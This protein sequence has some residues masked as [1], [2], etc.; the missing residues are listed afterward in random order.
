MPHADSHTGAPSLQ[1]HQIMGTA[2]HVDHGKTA[3]IRALTGIE[4]DTH[5]EEKKRGIT[6]NLGFAFLNTGNGD[7]IGIVDVP[8]H[9]DFVNTMVAGACGMDFVCL[10]IAAD[11]G[12]MP[13]T[14]EHLNIIEALGIRHGIV[15]LTKTDIV[16]EET[17]DMAQQEI[18]E[19]LEPSALNQAPV[20]AVSSATGQGIDTLKAAIL[21]VAAAVPARR[22]GEVFRMFADRIFMVKGFGAVVTGS[23]LSGSLSRESTVLL[24]PGSGRYRV[25]RM[26]RH[27]QEVE[28][29]FTG[30]RAS[31]NLVGLEKSAFSRGMVIADRELRSTRLLDVTIGL[32]AESPA[33]GLWSTV[34][35]LFG[36]F[37][38]QARIHLIDA[39]RLTGGG[40]ALAQIHLPQPCVAQNGDRFILRSSSSEK[41][42]GGGEVID[43]FPL[44]HRRRPPPLVK[45]L[46]RVAE[47]KLQELVATE[48]RKRR[49]ALSLREIGEALNVPV[50]ELESIVTGELPGDIEVFEVEG[51]LLIAAATIVKEWRRS[52][53]SSIETSLKRNPLEGMGR[54][55]EELLGPFHLDTDSSSRKVMAHILDKM[56]FDGALK[57]IG[58][59]WAD[60]RSA[61]ELSPEI[62]DQIAFVENLLHRCGMQTPLMSDLFAQ[63]RA[64][65]I[66]EK[67]L[68]DILRYLVRRKTVYRV[69]DDYIHGSVV[70]SAREK[71]V[72]HLHAHKEGVTVAQFRDL[73]SGNRKICLLLLAIFDAEGVTRREGDVRVYG[74]TGSS[75]ENDAPGDRS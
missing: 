74:K 9:R 40:R 50:K 46:Q 36:T 49:K 25:R 32:F 26:E 47:G 18:A 24:L 29:V 59:T 48:A 68:V 6:I 28:R 21:R 10:V 61:A 38:A 17:L 62:Q 5:P 63:S 51:E 20:I 66:E 16:D 45:T 8:G 35:F 70:E 14:R 52:A 15:A 39:D 42:L 57:K 34:D 41:T 60:P 33:L 23:V 31:L 71:L 55:L 11:S 19:F 30:D 67:R 69:Q 44:H 13:Q 2:G 27:G 37:E 54:S 43:A 75:P 73:V 64:R 3:L 56:V 58:A 4:C 53:Q 65:G 1:N 72:T 12:I 22:S 7:W